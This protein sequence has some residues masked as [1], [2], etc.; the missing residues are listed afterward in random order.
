LGGGAQEAASV[1]LMDSWPTGVFEGACEQV[2]V[3][4]GLGPMTPEM[5]CGRTTATTPIGSST[6]RVEWTCT[7]C[8][9][10][11]QRTRAIALSEFV[12][13]PAGT[14]PSWR[15]FADLGG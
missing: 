12:A 6:Q 13:V 9:F 5:L 14:L 10:P 3:S 4:V 8:L 1:E 7:S 2:E 15:I 11:D